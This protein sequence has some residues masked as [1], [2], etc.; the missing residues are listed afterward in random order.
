MIKPAWAQE[1]NTKIMGHLDR[2]Y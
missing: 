1:S 2:G